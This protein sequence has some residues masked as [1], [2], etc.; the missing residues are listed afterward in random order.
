MTGHAA[1]D[2]GRL[3]VISGPSGVGKGTVVRCLLQ[4]RPDLELSVSVTTRSPRPG[5]IDGVDYHFV[6][7]AT[8]AE[9]IERGDLLEWARVHRHRS[10]TPG[11]GLEERL[12]RGR[13]VVLEIDVQGAMQVRDRVADALLIFLAPPSEEELV[14]RLVRRGT[15]R[16]DELAVRQ[17]DR[18]R[19][20]AAAPAFDH[21]VTNDDLDDCVSQVAELVERR[22]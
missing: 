11:A 8:F 21:V 7:D 4:R 15:E 6:D 9:M 3:V 2:R 13:D 1:G 12:A 17:A 16:D 19:E 14:R 22:R 20:L 5:E 18:A 10:G